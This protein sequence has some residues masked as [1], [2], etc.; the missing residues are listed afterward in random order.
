MST[1]F[2]LLPPAFGNFRWGD[3]FWISP[4]KQKT[5]LWLSCNVVYIIP[6]LAILRQYHEY[7]TNGWQFN[8]QILYT[9]MLCQVLSKGC[10]VV[11]MLC[12]FGG[13]WC[14]ANVATYR[15]LLYSLLNH[16]MACIVAWHCLIHCD[17]IL[18]SNAAYIRAVFAVSLVIC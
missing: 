5:S 7:L 14:L 16:M 18:L 11:V 1:D 17:D 4:R 9:S 10:F 3:P 6:S 13:M 15:S 12:Q 2:N 8:C